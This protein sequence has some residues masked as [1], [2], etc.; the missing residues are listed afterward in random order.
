LAEQWALL[1]VL[2]ATVRLNLAGV[3]PSRVA[4]AG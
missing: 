4:A 2:R 1:G 3:V